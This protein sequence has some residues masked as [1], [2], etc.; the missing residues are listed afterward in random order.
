MSGIGSTGLSSVPSG[1]SATGLR[2]LQ[3][4]QQAQTALTAYNQAMQYQN[5]Q[6]LEHINTY[7]P[8][9]ETRLYLRELLRSHVSED[10]SKKIIRIICE[11]I[12][13]E[14][15]ELKLTLDLETSLLSFLIEKLS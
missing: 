11:Y 15:R 7:L 8:S 13:K 4:Q 3:Y 1:L 5:Q 2:A 9:D 10:D 14:E 6:Y 12:S